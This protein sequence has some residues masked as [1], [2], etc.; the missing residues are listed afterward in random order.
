[1]KCLV[2]LRHAKTEPDHPLGDYSRELT[3]RG[4]SD[5]LASAEAMSRLGVA[6]DLIVTS[7][8]ARAVQ[9]ASIIGQHLGVGASIIE[10][11]ELYLAPADR[12][13]AEVNRLPDI[14][15]TVLLV[16]HNPGML[17]LINGFLVAET[18]IDRLPTAAFAIIRQQTE[19][20]S[21]CSFELGEVNSIITS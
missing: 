16:G 11:P 20:W 5:A 2:A 19:R 8:A 3:N 10:V 15:D 21:E 18:H 4:R 7:S 12:L 14:S 1:M 13:L 17:D 9:T 6:P